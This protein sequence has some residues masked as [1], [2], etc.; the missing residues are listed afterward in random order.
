MTQNRFKQPILIIKK[1]Q[2]LVFHLLGTEVLTFVVRLPDF[3]SVA[4]EIAIPAMMMATSI[5]T[6][7]SR[8]TILVF[9]IPLYSISSLLS[10]SV[11]YKGEAF[12]M[13]NMPEQLLNPTSVSL[14]V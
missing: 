4:I 3:A 8:V 10:S 5:N 6:C 11:Q 12:R 13:I 2:P 14:S 7:L 9:A 1:I